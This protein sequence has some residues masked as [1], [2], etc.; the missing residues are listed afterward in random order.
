M[1]PIVTGSMSALREQKDDVVVE[2]S[3]FLN[4][5]EVDPDNPQTCRGIFL[6]F[7]IDWADDLVIEDTIDLVEKVD[8]NATWFVTHKTPLLDRLRENP[9]FELGLHPNFNNLLAGDSQNGSSVKEVIQRL[10]D[11]VPEACCLRSHSLCTSTKVLR[12]MPELG[13]THESNLYIPPESTMELQPFR[14]WNGVVRVPHGFE[15]D[16]FL[17]S[18]ETKSAGF[19]NHMKM[20]LQHGGARVFDF[21]PIHAYLNTENIARYEET[22]SIHKSPH[23]LIYQR[24]DGEGIRDALKTLIKLG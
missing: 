5:S 12:L 4:L 19:K 6:T 14:I 24:Y 11:Y 17:L 18:A 3:P 10:K 1:T 15:D 13:L 20:L 2:S 22:R 9:K 23:E 16:L 21:H 8:V 7:D